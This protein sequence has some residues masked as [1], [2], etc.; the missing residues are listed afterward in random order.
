MASGF[1]IHDA[2]IVVALICEQRGSGGADA[3]CSIFDDLAAGA[4]RV[5]EIAKVV[6]RIAV[7]RRRRINLIAR[8]ADGR[9]GQRILGAILFQELVLNSL[10]E[11]VYA[12]ARLFRSLLARQSKPAPAKSDDAV[13]SLRGDSPNLQSA[14]GSTEPST[15]LTLSDTLKPGRFVVCA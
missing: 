11:S 10:R 8:L 1:Q 15:K 6:E 4:N 13:A 14:F 3:E 9:R 12:V 7:T 5:E 2:A